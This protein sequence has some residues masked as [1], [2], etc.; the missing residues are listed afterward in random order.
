MFEL[1]HIRYKKSEV[2]INEIHDSSSVVYRYISRYS[3]ICRK[4]HIFL[5]S[6]LS[7]KKYICFL[8]ELHI[9]IDRKDCMFDRKDKVE[10]YDFISTEQ[11]GGDHRTS[12]AYVTELSFCVSLIIK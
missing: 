11:R 1:N 5:F 2:I 10:S 3:Y 6:Y 12:P 8:W 7:V 9:C 4:L